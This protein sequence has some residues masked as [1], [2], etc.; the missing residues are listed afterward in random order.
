VTDR[1]VFDPGVATFMDFRVPQEGGTCFV[2]VLPT[3]PRRAL[4]EYTVFSPE[5]WPANGTRRASAGTWTHAR[6][7]GTASR[8]PRSA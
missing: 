2:Y 3:D 6:G 1:P 4:V 7:A 5:V 8:A